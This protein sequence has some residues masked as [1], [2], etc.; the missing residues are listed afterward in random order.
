MRGQDELMPPRGHEFGSALG[1]D[2]GDRS[3][4]SV[5]PPSCTTVVIAK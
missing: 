2:R 5:Q 1:N 3:G 4:D